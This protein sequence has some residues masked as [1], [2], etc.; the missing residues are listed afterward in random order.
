MKRF[1]F[2]VYIPY[3]MVIY[4]GVPPAEPLV[5][6]VLKAFNNPQYE[7]FYKQFYR[8]ADKKNTIFL[9]KY[10]KR[11]SPKTMTD[12]YQFAVDP[13]RGGKYYIVKEILNNR[14]LNRQRYKANI[15]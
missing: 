3:V 5:A 7:V 12:A 15:E 4:F 9:S 8:K 10:K 2:E 14:A 11:L 1:L 13:I 6:K